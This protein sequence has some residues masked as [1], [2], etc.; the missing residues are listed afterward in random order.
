VIGAL[1][2]DE[3]GETEADLVLVDQRDALLDHAVGLEPLNALPARRG[4]Q[5]DAVA[6]LGHRE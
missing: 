2:G 4:R 3:H 1:H 6:D 5:A